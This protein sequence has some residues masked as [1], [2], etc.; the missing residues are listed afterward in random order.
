MSSEEKSLPQIKLKPGT[1]TIGRA[2]DNDTRVADKTVS[3]HHARIVTYFN[4]SYIEDLGSTN[5]TMVNGKRVKKH[6]VHPGDVVKL[7]NV[8]FT[9]ERG[10]TIDSGAGIDRP[11]KL[12]VKR[13]TRPIG[14]PL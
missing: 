8:H 7:G 12:Q 11:K 4:A 3:S 5:G 1:L 14:R 6:T 9:I 10:D 13:T 2:K